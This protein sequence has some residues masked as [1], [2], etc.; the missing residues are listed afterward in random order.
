MRSDL[1]LKLQIIKKILVVVII[2]LS[3]PLRIYGLLYGSVIGSVLC[4]FINTHYSR[5]FL[6]YSAWEQT[7]GIMPILIVSVLAGSIFFGADVALKNY[8]FV[9]FFR[10]AFGGVLGIVLFIAVAYVSKLGSIFEL[11]VI[12]KRK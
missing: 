2:A 5:K 6:N 1:F 9:H 3:F 12:A 8:Y 4:F 11:I 7:K 10:L